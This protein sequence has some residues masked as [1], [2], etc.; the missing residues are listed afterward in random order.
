MRDAANGCVPLLWCVGRNQ[1]T[2]LFLRFSGF[3]SF[4]GERDERKGGSGYFAGEGREWTGVGGLKKRE[5]VKRR[6]EEA[7]GENSDGGAEQ[8]GTEE[9]D[10]EWVDADTSRRESSCTPPSLYP[11]RSVLEYQ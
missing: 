11:D 9:R 4:V 7:G 5:K 8:A 6:A 2:L 1:S 3:A 10:G